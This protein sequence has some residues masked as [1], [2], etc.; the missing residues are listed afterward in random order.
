MNK[1]Y[2]K[3]QDLVRVLPA[4]ELIEFSRELVEETITKIGRIALETVLCMSAVDVAGEP[5]RG[6]EKGLVRIADENGVLFG[7]IEGNLGANPPAR[8][9]CDLCSDD[10]KDKPLLGL[11]I[12]RGVRQSRDEAGQWDGGDI[13]DP[14]T[15][16]VYRVRLHPKNGGKE[17]EVRGYLGISLFGRTQTWIRAE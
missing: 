17:L 4:L 10:R 3:G 9:V 13:L 16:K 2:I 11:V 15:G 8:R 5:R 1:S 7:R 12:L 14:D 6:R